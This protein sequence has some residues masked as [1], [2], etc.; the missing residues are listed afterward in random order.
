MVIIIYTVGRC[1]V[2]KL[3]KIKDCTGMGG[4]TGAGGVEPKAGLSEDLHNK[5][6]GI[7]SVNVYPSPT[8][9]D[10]F[11]SYTID[12]DTEMDIRISNVQ[13]RTML[14]DK[15]SCYKGTN[16]SLPISVKELPPGVYL[17]EIICGKERA[18]KR[19]TKM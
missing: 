5:V 8:H 11:I 7:N 19:F 6:I 12:K 4:G 9:S 3:V 10:V 17:M 2:A 13:G 1:V 16:S 14:T 18:V 15:I